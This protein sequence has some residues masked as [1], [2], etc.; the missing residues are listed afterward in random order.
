[1]LHERLK[2]AIRNN[3]DLNITREKITQASQI[4]FDDELKP[5]SDNLDIDINDTK[6]DSV[7]VV[8]RQTKK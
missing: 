6:N 8:K 2:E 5:D 4:R 7:S 1:M 3:E